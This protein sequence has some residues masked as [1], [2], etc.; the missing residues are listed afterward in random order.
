[1]TLLTIPPHARRQVNLEYAAALRHVAQVVA[2]APLTPRRLEFTS[3]VSD[4][5]S[6]GGVGHVLLAWVA[7]PRTLHLEFDHDGVVDYWSQPDCGPLSFDE[8]DAL[9]SL[10][11]WLREGLVEASAFPDP[12]GARGG[13]D[14]EP[15][16]AAS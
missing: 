6:P 8:G 11:A 4:G 10:F 14:D 3:I 16:R 9:G 5:S 1:M 13:S 2:S 7:G 12:A 15:G